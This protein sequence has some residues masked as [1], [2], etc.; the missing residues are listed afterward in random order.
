MTVGFLK[1]VVPAIASTNSLIAAETVL[2]AL[3]LLVGYS[4]PLDNYFMYMGHQGLYA[5]HD[6]YD[7]DINCYVCREPFI[8]FITSKN[9]N[10]YNN[11]LLVRNIDSYKIEDLLNEIKK[12]YSLNDP[13]INYKNKYIYAG[14]N[15]A[16]SYKN[17]LKYTFKDLISKNL[18]Q[19]NKTEN[20]TIL[21]EVL[22]LNL[23]EMIV[24]RIYI[25]E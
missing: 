18:I 25:N 23:K 6:K 17:I 10:E 20:N 21:L 8:R 3:K 22:D 9:K 15:L 11:N 12:Q 1:N 4:K 24:L 2:E 14:G 7:K 5:S 19:T 13:S 16:E